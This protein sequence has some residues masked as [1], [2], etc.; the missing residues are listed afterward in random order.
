MKDLGGAELA[1]LKNG[2]HDFSKKFE[3]F[4]YLLKNRIVSRIFITPAKWN[5][6]DE[7]LIFLS[8]C[9]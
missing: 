2:R 4:L 5:I 3:Y 6:R 7:T 9:I 1:C 8:A